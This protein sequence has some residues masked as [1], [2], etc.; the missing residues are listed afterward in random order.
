MA[1]PINQSL[2]KTATTFN[3]A[4]ST[5]GCPPSKI[6]PTF[7]V[8]ADPKY[9]WLAHYHSDLYLKNYISVHFIM[10]RFSPSVIAF[11]RSGSSARVGAMTLRMMSAAPSVKVRLR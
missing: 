11:V 6:V 7:Q 3:D 4:S 8:I 9:L 1:K 5:V 2:V 10:M